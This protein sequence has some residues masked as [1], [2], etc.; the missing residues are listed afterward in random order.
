[1]L[2]CVS[3]YELCKRWLTKHSKVEIGF[4]P[5]L[6]PMSHTFTQPCN[7]RKTNSFTKQSESLSPSS[8]MLLSGKTVKL[9]Q[10][11]V[12]Q[13]V[14]LKL[15]LSVLKNISTVALSASIFW[16]LT[17]V[18]VKLRTLM[19][20]FLWTKITVHADEMY[21]LQHSRIS[22]LESYSKEKLYPRVIQ[23]LCIT[24]TKI[25]CKED[26]CSWRPNLCSSGFIQKIATIFTDFSRTTYH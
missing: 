4:F 7:Q 14:V 9:R 26:H 25:K 13:Y 19:V 12:L 17:T 18:P 23:Q 10:A 8:H 11:P 21:I 22:L 1:M 24:L 3:Y 16:I 2:K 20:L 6:W 15:A 5:L